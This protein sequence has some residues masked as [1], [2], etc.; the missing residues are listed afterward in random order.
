MIVG[1][2]MVSITFE[3]VRFMAFAPLE[4]LERISESPSPIRMMFQ[5]HSIL[6]H[7]R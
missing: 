1:A 7:Q 6:M 3:S 2:A 5:H 4:A